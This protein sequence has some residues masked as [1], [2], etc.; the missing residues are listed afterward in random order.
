MWL[1][2]RARKRLT[3]SN[4]TVH[5]Q[6]VSKCPHLSSQNGINGNVWTM[7]LGSPS[8]STGSACGGASCASDACGG[9]F[10]T[11]RTCGGASYASDTCG[12]ASSSSSTRQHSLQMQTQVIRNIKIV[13]PKKKYISGF[14]FL[15]LPSNE[16]ANSPPLSD[17]AN[18]KQA[19]PNYKKEIKIS[20]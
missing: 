19:T 14:S 18:P 10:C 12:G 5:I 17:L 13:E 3:S 8:G 2:G 11:S 7:T 4:S 1:Q 16:S 20:H 15:V 9:A 6:Q